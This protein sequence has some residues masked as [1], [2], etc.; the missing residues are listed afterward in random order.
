MDALED[1]QVRF[2]ATTCPAPSPLAGNEML[3]SP[4]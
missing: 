1:I 3:G 2:R 4:A